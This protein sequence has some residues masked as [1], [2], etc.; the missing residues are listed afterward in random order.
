MI[1]LACVLFVDLASFAV[2]DWWVVLLLVLA[3]GAIFVV[4]LAWWTPHPSRLPWLAVLGFG[5]WVLVVI[6]GSIVFGG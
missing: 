6:G 1:G 4:A 2:V 5:L 3:W